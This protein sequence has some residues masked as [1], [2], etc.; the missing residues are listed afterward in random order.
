[1]KLLRFAPVLLLSIPLTAGAADFRDRDALVAQINQGSEA[2]LADAEEAL[3]AAQADLADAQANGGDVAAAQAKVDAAQADVAAAQSQIDGAAPIV[4]QLTDQQVFALNR[5]LNN[6]AHNGLAPIQIDP[7]LLQRI[8]DEDLGNREIQQLT[9][10]LELRE[11]FDQ[12]AARF[13][14]KAVASGKPAFHDRADRMR[15]RGAALEE[16]FLAR[17]DDSAPGSQTASNDAAAK[18]RDEA[19]EAA[20]EAAREHGKHAARD[21]AHQAALDQANAKHAH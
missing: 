13:E 2:S 16:K 10:G 5:A 6:A 12:H 8:A 17:V 3:A 9:Q 15:E 18:V 20:R 1:M 19:G 7:A 11:R 21:A 4:A 14:A